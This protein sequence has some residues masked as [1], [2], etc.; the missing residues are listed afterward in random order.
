MALSKKQRLFLETYLINGFNAT[1]AAITAGYAE[2]SARSIGAENLTKPDILA[3]IDA[4]L[5]EITLSR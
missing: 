3:E 5:A 1:R 2:R 4:Y